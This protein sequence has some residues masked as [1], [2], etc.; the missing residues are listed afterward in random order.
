MKEHLLWWLRSRRRR[1]AFTAALA[2]SRLL[3]DMG[4]WLIHTGTD[5]LTRNGKGASS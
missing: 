2:A 4:F 1:L 3:T 5:L